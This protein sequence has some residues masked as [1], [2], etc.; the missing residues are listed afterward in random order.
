MTAPLHQ[1]G[2]DERRLVVRHQ[3]LVADLVREVLA[4]VPSHVDRHDLCAAAGEALGRAALSFDPTSGIRFADH[5]S[6]LIRL[7]LR[8]LLRSLPL[9][10]SITRA[11][12]CAE[13]LDRRLDRLEAAIA[14]LSD[15]HRAVVTSYFFG[16]HPLARIADE[17]G[18]TEPRVSRLLSDALALLCDALNHPVAPAPHAVVALRRPGRAVRRTSSVRFEYL[19]RRRGDAG[20]LAHLH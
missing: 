18:V 2:P 17:L 3:P 10:T 1:L 20:R 8:D 4:R 5:A 13:D 11:A 7:A 6:A 12:S 19:A 9:R 15:R 14:V 16:G